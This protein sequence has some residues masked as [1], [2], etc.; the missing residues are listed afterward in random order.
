MSA[1]P[2]NHPGGNNPPT[3][4]TSFQQ[5]MAQ[6]YPQPGAAAPMVNNPL[7]ANIQNITTAPMPF[8]PGPQG[9]Q[10]NDF[11]PPSGTLPSNP[12]PAV[13]NSSGM[14]VMGTNHQPP[15]SSS[16]AAAKAALHKLSSTMAPHSSNAASKSG[17]KTA[18]N[19]GSVAAA[20]SGIVFNTPQ[21][22]QLLAQ[23]DYRDKLMWATRLLMG[24]NSVNGFLRSTA[25]VQRIKKQ[26]ARQNNSTKQSRASKAFGD[27]GNPESNPLLSNLNSNGAPATGKTPKGSGFDQE[28]EEQLKKEIMNPRT[29]KKLKTEF[30][31]GLV[32]CA[33]VCNVLRGVLF[34]MDTSLA[35]SLPPALIINQPKKPAK[36]TFLV[37]SAPQAG[38]PQAANKS[39]Q[40]PVATGPPSAKMDPPAMA[41]AKTG[42]ST[43]A[44]N[45][46]TS[47]ASPG[48][49]ES[50]TLRKF[51]KK[52]HVFSGPPV[53]LP[54]V[55]ANGKRLCT[56]KEHQ[57]RVFQLLR[58][59]P[60]KQGD[61]CAARLSSRDLWILAK[62]VK[63][64]PV[65]P[66]SPPHNLQ[67]LEFLQL[68]D[69]KRD[70]L[71]R[72]KVM[73]QDVEEGEDGRA[74]PVA[75][76]LVLPLPRN[77]AEA[78]EWT[79]RLK[80]GS[81]VYAMYP[82]TTSLY[83]AT[84]VDS[85]TYCREDDDIIVVEF[86][87]EEVDLMTGKVPSY[88]IPARF[89]TIIPREFPASQNPKAAAAA[90]A[91]ASAG[92]KRKSVSSVSASSSKKRSSTAS[93][94]GAD[95][96]MLAMDFDAVAGD[97][98]LGFDGLDLDFDK[99]LEEGKQQDD[100]PSF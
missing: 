40:Q 28:E 2:N 47:T 4:T 19:R 36:F 49:A 91:A 13:L 99:P 55:D 58:Y 62:V 43:A 5:L 12:L 37:P 32:F 17:K 53:D 42:V 66:T 9:T 38:V 27:P 90:A 33:T 15:A 65:G 74:T 75:R 22:N 63:D 11:V 21:Q 23:C 18:S 73:L 14:P 1:P 46:A 69:V 26:R 81:R 7:A 60:L 51:R 98:G 86:D 88:H 20:S 92:A 30:E 72:D 50:S 54:E 89:V 25:T 59:R 85:T 48:G 35:S 79:T 67:P 68:S 45:T 80:K 8:P 16:A 3:Y 96:D 57:Y 64:Y 56:K 100:F 78:S 77:V 83:P 93:S 71:F 84:V 94:P 61:F 6:R 41:Q 39:T 44:T 95:F 10:R 76:N 52:K 87:G 97:A 70:A 31:Q 29:A 24:G 34:D 82:Q